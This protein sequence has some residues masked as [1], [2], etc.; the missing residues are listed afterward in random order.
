MGTRIFLIYREIFEKLNFSKKINN[1]SLVE[2]ESD[3]ASQW[4]V[5]QFSVVREEASWWEYR[6]LPSG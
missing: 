4:E 2:L 5:M 6:K 3:A 1:E